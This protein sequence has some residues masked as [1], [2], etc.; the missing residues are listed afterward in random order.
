MSSADCTYFTCQN[1]LLKFLR[2]KFSKINKEGVFLLRFL[3]IELIATVFEWFIV[4][5]LQQAWT[6]VLR[7]PSASKQW[8][9]RSSLL[10]VPGNRP[11]ES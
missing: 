9:R 8:W 10:Q 7:M 4:L 5:R 3:A 11:Y 6:H 2:I 1:N